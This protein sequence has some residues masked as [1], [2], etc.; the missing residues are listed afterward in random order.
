MRSPAA[1]D[2]APVASYHPAHDPE[3]DM[4]ELPHAPEQSESDEPAKPERHLASQI[5]NLVMFVI[6]GI[7]LWWM[8]RSLGWDRFLDMVDNVGW[9]FVAIIALD[10]TSLCFDA[11]ALHAFMRP[12]ARMIK[13][14]R[15]LAAQ[16]SGRAINVLTP[17]GALGE[18][19]KLTML[20]SHAPRARVL[21]S[22]VLLN[23]S[24]F[25]ISVAVMMIGTP[26]TFLL[27]DLPNTVKI[28]AGVGFAVIIPLMIALGFVIKRGATSTIVDIIRRT[29]LISADRSAKWKEKLVEVDKHIREL[30]KNRSAGTWKGILWVGASKLALYTSTIILLVAVDI[31]LNPA[32][33]IGVFSVGVLIQWI[34]S[35]VPMG[36]GL[37]DGGNYAMYKVLGSSG[38]HGM[39]V[40]ML[41][42]ARS[43]TVAILGLGAMAVMW[44]ANRIVQARIQ[45]KLSALRERAG[46]EPG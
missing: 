46:R 42:R 23:L 20:V 36:L 43:V 24:M 4:S 44:V 1:A 34:S 11:A 6:G 19:I 27:V 13:Y 9:W 35:I 7:A 21:S 26:L 32:L 45:K 17:G 37:A 18:A 22:I 38:P 12:E 16:A 5:F 30:H 10:L 2:A 40:T 8:L 41:N 28:A 31:D 39:A 29:R 25:Y 15:V 14:P 33:V 3:R